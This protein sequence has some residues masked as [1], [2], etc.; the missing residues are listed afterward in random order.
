MLTS[1]R[2][3]RRDITL[4]L[5]GG[6]SCERTLD[7]E[8]RSWPGPHD[9]WGHPIRIRIRALEPRA[10]EPLGTKRPASMTP[11]FFPYRPSKLRALLAAFAV[12][13]AAVGAAALVR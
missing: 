4:L 13:A 8:W 3:G 12:V 9:D 11:R 6:C 7:Q 5:R 10:I 1:A 2:R